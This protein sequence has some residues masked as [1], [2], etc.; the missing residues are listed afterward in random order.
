MLMSLPYDTHSL[1][2]LAS[3][4]SP[5][6]LKDILHDLFSCPFFRCI[7]AYDLETYN[8]CTVTLSVQSFTYL[9]INMNGKTQLV[10]GFV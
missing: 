3:R 1:Q 2:G 8:N 7:G 6:T 10:L 5:P 9:P 4:M